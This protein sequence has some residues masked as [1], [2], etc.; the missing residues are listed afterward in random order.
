MH[1]QNVADIENETSSSAAIKIPKTITMAP[2]NN[3]TPPILWV[4]GDE[5]S[6]NMK[7]IAALIIGVII[8]II[9]VL[10][11]AFWI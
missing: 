2:R 5:L 10:L 11:I 7:K 3:A 9:G 6:L 4:F 1:T 8:G